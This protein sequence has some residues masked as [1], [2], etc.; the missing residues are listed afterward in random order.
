MFSTRVPLPFCCT[1]PLPDT[2]PAKV[3]TSLRLNTRLL[4]LVILPATEP[5]APPLPICSVPALMLVPPVWV[6]APASTVIPLPFC[7]TAPAPDIPPAYT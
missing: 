3:K 6:L 7:S 4:L 1:A 5:V 2:T